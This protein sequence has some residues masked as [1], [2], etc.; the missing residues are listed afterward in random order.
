MRGPSSTNLRRSPVRWS[1]QGDG[2]RNEEDLED[3]IPE[4]FS[5]CADGLRPVVLVRSVTGQLRATA[6][7]ELAERSEALNNG[8]LVLHLLP[9]PEQVN[10]WVFTHATCGGLLD[11][12]RP[13]CHS[14]AWKHRPGTHL[15]GP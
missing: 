7:R 5:Q 13:E 10:T 4:V 6:E 8:L 11:R 14:C 2:P 12:H 9:P 15:K 3:E 1:I